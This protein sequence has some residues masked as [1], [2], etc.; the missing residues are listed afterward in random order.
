VWPVGNGA[1]R[2]YDCCIDG[3][4]SP[5]YF[6]YNFIEIS[7]D[8]RNKSRCLIKTK[9]QPVLYMRKEDY[10]LSSET[11]STWQTGLTSASSGSISCIASLQPA[12]TVM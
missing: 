3:A 12:R 7:V 8:S 2:Y 1:S 6:G 4:I 10:W 5:E 11:G 9:H